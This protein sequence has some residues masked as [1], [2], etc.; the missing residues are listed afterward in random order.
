MLS[1]SSMQSSSSSCFSSPSPASSTTFHS[2]HHRQHPRK[3]MRGVRMESSA[4]S[5]SSPIRTTPPLISSHP[6]ERNRKGPK[7]LVKSHPLKLY[8]L[9]TGLESDSFGK[10]KSLTTWRNSL[11]ILTNSAKLTNNSFIF[12]RV[13]SAGQHLYHT[14]SRFR[15]DAD[16]LLFPGH[17]LLIVFVGERWLIWKWEKK[18]KVS[19]YSRI[20][21][22]NLWSLLEMYWRS[23]RITGSL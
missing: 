19:G 15:H 7:S 9:Q 1:S 12:N 20:V 22:Q 21:K 5:S 2:S 8:S 3:T 6:R 4:E 16:L 10:E 17:S 23:S 13:P 14:R 11:G 18:R